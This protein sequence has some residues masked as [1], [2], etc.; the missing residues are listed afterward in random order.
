MKQKKINKFNS[1]L[2][3]INK[4]IIEGYTHESIVVIL[5]TKHDLDL[6]VSTFRS[7]Y[8]TR[9]KKLVNVNEVDNTVSDNQIST[10]N[11][12]SLNSDNDSKQVKSS[13]LSQFNNDKKPEQTES[14]SPISTLAERQKLKGDVNKS[15]NKAKSLLNSAAIEIANASNK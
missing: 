11:S 4:L 10:I 15:R 5:K 13:F 2:P 3:T 7:Y 12:S 9:A 1:L 6:P 8:Y 14:S